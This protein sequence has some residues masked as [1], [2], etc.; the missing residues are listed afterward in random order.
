MKASELA[1]E[2]RKIEAE[3]GTLTAEIVVRK[4]SR[5][6]H[7][8]H[9]EFEWDDAT[10]AH[11]QRITVA[12]ALI[13]RAQITVE[14]DEVVVRSPVYLRD[15]AVDPDQQ[16]Y[17]RLSKM[18]PNDSYQALQAELRRAETFLRRAH[19]IGVALGYGGQIHGMLQDLLKML[20]RPEPRKRPR[21]GDRPA[22]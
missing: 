15:P 16:G 9:G 13:R 20:N 18:S 2:L 4:A 19:D 11:E 22:A 5:P 3:D 1:A 14:S 10:A 7:P 17:R 12:R 21:D 6:T 8:L